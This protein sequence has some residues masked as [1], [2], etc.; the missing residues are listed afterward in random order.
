MDLIPQNTDWDSLDAARDINENGQIV[1]QGI[2]NGET[3]AFLMTPV[4]EP[5][6]FIMLIIG[7]GWLLKKTKQ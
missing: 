6:L 4:P 5:S 7:C 3:R 2:I 1:G